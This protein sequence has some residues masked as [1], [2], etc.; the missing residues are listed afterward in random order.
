MI[1]VGQGQFCYQLLVR[2]S[3]EKPWRSV[4]VGT[5]FGSGGG[6]GSSTTRLAGSRHISLS[7]LMCHRQV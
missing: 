1:V 6:L 2:Y 7:I 5:S 3:C 4:K